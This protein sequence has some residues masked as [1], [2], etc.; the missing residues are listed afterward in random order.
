MKIK[1]GTNSSNES[2]WKRQE[3]SIISKEKQ[4]ATKVPLKSNHYP[5]LI[6]QLVQVL[7]VDALHMIYLFIQAANDKRNKIDY[8]RITEIDQ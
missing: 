6:K 1:I 5:P 4:H 3:P 8:R 7:K 2:N